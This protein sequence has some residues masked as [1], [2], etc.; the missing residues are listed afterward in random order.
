MIYYC[1]LR[2]RVLRRA[3]RVSISGQ[4]LLVL[5]QNILK[6]MGVMVLGGGRGTRPAG[7]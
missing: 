1:S 7:S 3:L 4:I 6:H 2:G 5:L